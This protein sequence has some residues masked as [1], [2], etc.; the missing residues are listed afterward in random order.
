MVEIAR[1]VDS[2][3]LT[4]K[5]NKGCRRLPPGGLCRILVRVGSCGGRSRVGKGLMAE[6]LVVVTASMAGTRGGMSRFW[7]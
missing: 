5:I 3:A 6:L 7:R 4:T 1:Y 2:D